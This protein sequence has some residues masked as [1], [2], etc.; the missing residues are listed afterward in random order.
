MDFLELAKERY[1]VRKFKDTPI[2]PEKLDKIIEAGRVAP[3]AT[4]N[5]PQRI[6]IIDDAESIEK[7]DRCTR[8]RYGAPTAL[9]V[10]YDKDAAWVR[11][12]DGHDAGEVDATIVCTH[13]MME[14]ADLGLGSLWA[15]HFDPEAI[16]SE[17]QLPE[18][19]IPVA[20]LDLGYAT[21]ECK[22]A[23]MHDQVLSKDQTVFRG[24]FA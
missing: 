4:N 18:N 17:F 13:M 21:D 11:K 2:E 8:M 10:C 1:S 14:A 16:R 22:P 5:Q 24:T 20:V 15:M 6:L 9:L 7:L 3:T 12:Y 19:Y 23:P